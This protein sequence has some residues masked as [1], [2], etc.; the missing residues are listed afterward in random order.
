MS[1]GLIVKASDN[2]PFELL[3]QF[4]I[5]KTPIVYRGGEMDEEVGGSTKH[6]VVTLVDVT[7]EIDELL[8]TNISI[9]IS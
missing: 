8:K 6:F 3:E 9:I 1:Y 7:R 4:G 2:V 5:P